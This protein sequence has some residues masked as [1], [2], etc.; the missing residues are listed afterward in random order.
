M[1]E[2]ENGKTIKSTKESIEQTALQLFSQ[3]GYTAVSIRDICSEVG[4]KE[5]TVYYHFENKQAILDSLFSRIDQLIEG[6]KQ[7]FDTAFNTTEEVPDVAMCDVAVGLLNNYLLNPFVYKMIS[8]LTI[9]RMADERAAMQY[10][11]IVF[12][13]PLQQQEQVFAQMIER[14]YIKENNP[15]ILAQEY[16]AVIYLAFQKN[17]LGYELTQDKIDRATEEIRLNMMDI[18]RKM[19]V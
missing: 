9:E 13:L 8:V 18:Y 15:Q 16:Y 10:A 12:D 2:M 17:C 3:K 6:M 1:K 11:R 5:S 4:I 19:K 7:R 14:G